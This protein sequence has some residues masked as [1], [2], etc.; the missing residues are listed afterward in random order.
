MQSP[1]TNANFV[2]RPNNTISSMSVLIPVI[3]EKKLYF[4]FL[5]NLFPLAQWTQWRTVNT[6]THS[7][8]SDA[9]WRTVTHSY[10]ISAV[11]ALILL[12]EVRQQTHSPIKRNPD[13]HFLFL[14]KVPENEPLLFPKRCLYGDSWALSGLFYVSLKFLTKVP[15]NKGSLSSYQRP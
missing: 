14:S 6:V 10:D 12:G 9:Q 7:E 13:M 15:L 1:E 3:Q 2:I 11:L 4:N 5:C 8:H